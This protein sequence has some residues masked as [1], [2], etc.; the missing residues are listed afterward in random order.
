MKMKLSL[1]VAAAILTACEAPPRLP[2]PTPI[3]FSIG[4][5]VTPPVGCVE[6]RKANPKGDC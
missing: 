2:E 3:P 1:L 4:E 5:V 6:L